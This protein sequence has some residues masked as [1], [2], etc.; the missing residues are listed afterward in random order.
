MKKKPFII[1]I[2]MV[3]AILI[4]VIIT[5]H[6][7]AYNKNETLLTQSSQNYIDTI[8][9]SDMKSGDIPGASILIIKDNKVFLNKGY[10]YAN[11]EKKIKAKPT[12]RYEIASNTKAFTGYAI[13][14]LA[15]NGKLSLNDHISKYIPGFYMKYDDKKQDITIKQLLGQKSVIPA[16]ITSEDQ[17]EVYGDSIKNLVQS[18]K[19]KELNHKPGDTFEY[20]NMNYDIL[21]L[22]IQNVSKESYNTYIKDHILEP[23]DMEHTTFKKTNSKNKH[24]A[25]GY[26][27]SGGAIKKSAPSFNIGDTPSAF[28]MSNT[29]DLEH[30]VKMQL[31]PSSKTKDIVKASQKTINES[32]G[33][34]GANGYAAGWFTNAHAD[35]IYHT[36]TLD[37]YS[38]VILLNPKKSYGIV[39]LA[40]MN[41]NKVT[42][43]ADH[44]NAQVMNHKHYTTIETKI[45]QAHNINVIISI[46][47]M[48]G[49]VISLYFILRRLFAIKHGKY[50]VQRSK[51]SLYAFILVMVAFVLISVAMYLLPYFVL[52]NNSW[53]FVMTWLPSHAKW[54][55]FS[56]YSCIILITIL[57]VIIILSQ[58]RT[59]HSN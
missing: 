52:G 56:F 26:E 28:L 57:L 41:S 9:K 3:I 46:I 22:I 44:L 19:G 25:V 37:N 23:L 1:T 4:A 11:V 35:Y 38:S 20:S 30:W 31:A 27:Q 47:S 14:E 6:F 7:W 13:L 16:D 2:I 59:L 50:K 15:K 54:A 24:E 32:Q 18:I 29:R 48:I 33:E 55:L 53:S 12:T 58:K 49:V 8:V 45:D 39:V 40:N 42:Q 43:L 34:D 21:G 5:K 17:T 36:G 51:A 10:G